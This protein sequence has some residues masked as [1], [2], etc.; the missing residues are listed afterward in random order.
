[1]AAKLLVGGKIPFDYYGQLLIPEQGQKEHQWDAGRELDLIINPAGTF[2]R[3]RQTSY[4]MA[5]RPSMLSP[6]LIVF[7]NSGR[8]VFPSDTGDGLPSILNRY[9]GQACRWRYLHLGFDPTWW[10]AP[11][12]KLLGE[13]KQTNFVRRQGLE[14]ISLVQLDERVHCQI[15][16]FMPFMSFTTWKEKLSRGG[17][18]V[19][20][21]HSK[22]VWAARICLHHTTGVVLIKENIRVQVVD[23]DGLQSLGIY[24]WHDVP[25]GKHL[26]ITTHGSQR[27]T[28][29]LLAGDFVTVQSDEDSN[30]KEIEGSSLGN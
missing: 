19:D 6:E 16:D 13:Q 9:T 21:K 11:L 27:P 7:N 3:P 15:L 12:N 8:R 10:V 23:S 22:Q 28:I 17:R 24:N 25:E 20:W 4:L 14:V 30:P 29:H 2:T 18:W 26:F 5:C 1:M